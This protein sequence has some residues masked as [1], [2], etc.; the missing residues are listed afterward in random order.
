M[1]S[2]R[3][4][5]AARMVLNRTRK[6]CLRCGKTFIPSS[7]YQKYCG[8]QKIRESCSHLQSLASM[9]KARQNPE[10]FRNRSISQR[11]W[12]EK[13]KLS[14]DYKEFTRDKNLKKEYGITLK[15]YLEIVASQDS[16]CALCHC[17]LDFTKRW[18]PV[19]HDH[20]TGKIRGI[21]HAQCN[22]GIG[23]LREDPE[24]CRQAAVYLEKHR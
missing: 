20:E 4:S 6:I 17:P 18:P 16:R 7:F 9:R 19:D 24:V 12:R 13:R 15:K 2:P 22:T 8:S 3:K 21:L 1:L 23:N 11:A 14:S 5:I 10:T